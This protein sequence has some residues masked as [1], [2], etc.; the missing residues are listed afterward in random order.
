[1]SNLFL[2][3]AFYG[4]GWSSCTDI[5]HGIYAD[6]KEAEE[7][8]GKLTRNQSAKPY[9]VKIDEKALM[10]LKEILKEVEE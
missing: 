6:S 9:I 1:M 2:V 4:N 8:W 10:Q 7:A 5:V 3:N